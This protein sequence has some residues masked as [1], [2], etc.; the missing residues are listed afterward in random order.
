MADERRRQADQ[1]KAEGTSRIRLALAKEAAELARHDGAPAL[2]RTL[3]TL[4]DLGYL[5]QRFLLR[6]L[7]DD[8]LR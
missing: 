2:L 7:P 8:L 6:R 1:L 3:Q 4:V 5:D